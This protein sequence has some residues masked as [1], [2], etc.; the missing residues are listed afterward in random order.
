MQ[1]L[2]FPQ[3][4]PIPNI[5]I[6]FVGLTRICN[7]LATLC[8]LLKRARLFFHVLFNRLLFDVT[9]SFKIHFILLQNVSAQTR[10]TNK[11]SYHSYT[12]SNSKQNWKNAYHEK[13]NGSS[14]M[15]WWKLINVTPRFEY[16]SA[17]NVCQV[18]YFFPPFHSLQLKSI[19]LMN[20]KSQ[21][22][23]MRKW[24][25]ISGLFC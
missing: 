20:N 10:A 12:Y 6:T 13:L 24:F 2:Y 23:R 11:Q 17:R 4:E 5:R 25:F 21:S 18:W 9:F 22:A 8:A 7:A 1:I 16:V 15:K 3:Y 14:I 19:E